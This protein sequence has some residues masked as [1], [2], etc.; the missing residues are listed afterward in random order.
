MRPAEK[1]PGGVGAEAR[2][3]GGPGGARGARPEGR[4]TGGR[5]GAER[6]VPETREAGGRLVLGDRDEDS[7]TY[8]QTVSREGDRGRRVRAGGKVGR[9]SR[10]EN[11]AFAEPAD[12]E[13]TPPQSPRDSRVRALF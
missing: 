13:T 1:G 9:Q 6:T 8:Q 2:T 10:G 5:G 12:P 7:R 11:Y 4:G 3:Q